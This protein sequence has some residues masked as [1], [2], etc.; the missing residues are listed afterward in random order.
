MDHRTGI[1]HVFIDGVEQPLDSRHTR[2]YEA[3]KDRVID[4]TQQ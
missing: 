1:K 3:F 2:L 4:T